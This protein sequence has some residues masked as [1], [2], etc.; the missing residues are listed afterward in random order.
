MDAGE[1]DPFDGDTLVLGGGGGG[2][3]DMLHVTCCCCDSIQSL[4][5]LFVVTYLE[6]R[7]CTD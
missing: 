1:P 4:S 2:D 5:N 6:L 3:S 7:D